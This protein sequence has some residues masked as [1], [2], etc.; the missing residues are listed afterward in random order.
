MYKKGYVCKDDTYAAWN[1]TYSV[2]QVIGVCVLVLGSILVIGGSIA[3]FRRRHLEPLRSRSIG[4][5]MLCSIG[6][7]LTQ[8]VRVGVEEAVTAPKMP[9]DVTLVSSMVFPVFAGTPMM[10]RIIRLYHMYKVQRRKGGFVSGGD[11]R[12]LER[13]QRALRKEASCTSPTRLYTIFALVSIPSLIALGVLYWD[14]DEFGNGCRNCGH[15][16]GDLFV[17]LVIGAMNTAV[18]VWALYRTRMLVDTFHVRKEIVHWAILWVIILVLTVPFEAVPYLVD[19]QQRGWFNGGAMILIG[20]FGTMII[21]VV[22]PTLG[23]YNRG[24]YALH[25]GGKFLLVKEAIGAG[26]GTVNPLVDGSP[27]PAKHRYS[28]K[29]VPS[30]ANLAGDTSQSIV[31]IGGKP[32]AELTLLDYLKHPLGFQAFTAHLTS[33]FSVENIKFWHDVEYFRAHFHDGEAGRLQALLLF[34]LY[35][36]EKGPLWVNVSS[37]QR[38]AV[39]KRVLA[40]E[41]TSSDMFDECQEEIYKLMERD[42]FPRFQRSALYERLL[43]GLRRERVARVAQRASVRNMAGESDAGSEGCCCCKRRTGRSRRSLSTQAASS[44]EEWDA[45]KDLVRLANGGSQRSGMKRRSPGG[46]KDSNASIEMAR[47]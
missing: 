7:L 44:V 1:E 25:N 9:C 24:P 40:A 34:E 14:E 15:T 31:L 37:A 43:L 11:H 16:W 2:R 38:E 27:T 29:R 10:L 39:A 41:T 4:L 18:T 17:N 21:S 47:V 35:V 36:D 23:T 5:V 22:L 6:T 20:A 33:E 3:L 19:V 28:V 13:L 12:S 26:Q 30:S 32:V 42:S 46:H 45:S 8:L